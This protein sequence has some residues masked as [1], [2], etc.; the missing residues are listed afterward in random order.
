M[1]IFTDL[2]DEV[3][4]ET[5]IHLHAIERAA[6]ANL[7]LVSR[8]VRSSCLRILFETI[9]LYPDVMIPQAPGIPPIL[10]VSREDADHLRRYIK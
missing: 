3:L 10:D 7:S 8:A 5:T 6:V 4:Y 2:P 9:H 1:T